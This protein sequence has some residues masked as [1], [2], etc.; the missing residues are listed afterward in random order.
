MSA[1][2]PVGGPE[3]LSGGG[4]GRAKSTRR[5]G[6]LPAVYAALQPGLK[7]CPLGRSRVRPQP[8]CMLTSSTEAARAAS[9]GLQVPQPGRMDL[10]HRPRRRLGSAGPGRALRRGVCAGTLAS[11]AVLLGGWHAEAAAVGQ[12]DWRAPLEGAPAVVRAFLAP[13]DRYAPGHR[14]VDLAAAPGA[15]VVAAGPGVVAFAGPVAGRGVVSVE[16]P[17]GLRTTYEP[18][19][20]V[21]RPGD[22]VAAGTLLGLLAGA[23]GHCLPGCLHWGAR[24]AAGYLDPM[25]LLGPVRVRLLP[26]WTAG[27]AA[28]PSRVPR[29]PASA[30]GGTFRASRTPGPAST[31]DRL[32][33]G[34]AALGLAA[35]AAW[36][37]R[38]APP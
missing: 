9:T 13:V 36:A 35:A 25:S 15:R 14:G 34:A 32:P 1:P 28:V 31:G 6:P 27:A 26:V 19:V 29:V 4:Y 8:G 21:V 24:R 22:P 10:A 16:H 12:P 38:R 33:A 7:S 37:L 30:A 11:A 20:A 18:V 2:P 23:G 3:G 5:D 17:G